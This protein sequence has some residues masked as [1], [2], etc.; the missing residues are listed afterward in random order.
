[1]HDPTLLFNL[2][3]LLQDMGRLEEARAAYR[4]ALAQD[5]TLADA[6]YNLSVLCEAR[7]AAREALRHLN[8][9]RRLT[10]HSAG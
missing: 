10:E 6:H 5:D 2:G 9:Y 4:A 7:G 8:H 3:V 1:M